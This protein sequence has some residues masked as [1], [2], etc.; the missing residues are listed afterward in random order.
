[1]KGHTAQAVHDGPAALACLIEFSPQVILM[2]IGMPG[3]NGYEVARL[4]RTLPGSEHIQ[5]IALTGWGQKA[6]KL[7]ASAAGFDNHLTKPV[8]TGLL[9]NLLALGKQ[10]SDLSK[11]E[12]SKA[13][14][15]A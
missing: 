12:A 7:N 15:S 14:L 10:S 6:D 5:L 11:P 9:W 8:D 4:I 1:L 3:M 13:P 2:D